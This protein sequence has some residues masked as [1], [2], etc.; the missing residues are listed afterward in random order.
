[1]KLDRT[2]KAPKTTSPDS[3]Q[4]RQPLSDLSLSN[5]TSSI[6]PSVKPAS[7]KKEEA[8][9]GVFS[10][11]GRQSIPDRRLKLKRKLDEDHYNTVLSP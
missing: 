3:D 1:M 4:H 8:S 5:E 2:P 6:S 7:D 10:K 9:Y 11:K